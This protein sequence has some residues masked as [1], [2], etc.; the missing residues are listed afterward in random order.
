MYTHIVS[1]RNNIKRSL[2]NNCVN[3]KFVKLMLLPAN[4]YLNYFL[5]IFI[6][7]HWS[8]KDQ[9]GDTV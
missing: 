1:S 5:Y 3:I 9:L 2:K 8:F 4:K 7:Y 6:A